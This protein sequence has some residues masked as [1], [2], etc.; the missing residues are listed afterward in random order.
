MNN[1]SFLHL[2]WCSDH[3]L[4]TG[5]SLA[6]RNI[7]I[8]IPSSRYVHDASGRNLTIQAACEAIVRS[9]N[10]LS[11]EGVTVKDPIS[12]EVAT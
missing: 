11:Q 12:K 5:N 3:T 9:F 7:L 8:I 6:S 2:T 10:Q 1:E 4:Y